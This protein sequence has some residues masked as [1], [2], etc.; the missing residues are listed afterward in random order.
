[1]TGFEVL[2]AY[3]CKSLI[4]LSANIKNE[5]IDLLMCATVLCPIMCPESRLLMSGSYCM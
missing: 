3:S 5:Y 1:M 2:S 4:S